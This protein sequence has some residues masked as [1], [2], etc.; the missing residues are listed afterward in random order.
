M[1]QLLSLC[2]FC[3]YQCISSVFHLCRD[4]RENQLLHTGLS[5]YWELGAVTSFQSDVIIFFLIFGCK[6]VKLEIC[7]Y[8]VEQYN[9]MLVYL[10]FCPHP[11]V[12]MGKFKVWDT[13]IAGRL[14]PC[15]WKLCILPSSFRGL[16]QLFTEAEEASMPGAQPTTLR[17]RDLG[18]VPPRMTQPYQ[19]VKKEKALSW[20]LE[21]CTKHGHKSTRANGEV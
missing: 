8:I 3:H 15:P 9:F 6:F 16:K 20:D 17:E 19:N 5:R 11:K 1:F 18:L 4:E 12:C 10:S 2:T 13:G 7:V 14:T 21:A